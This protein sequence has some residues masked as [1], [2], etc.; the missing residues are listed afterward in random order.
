VIKIDSSGIR[1]MLES[2][3]AGKLANRVS[4]AGEKLPGSKPFWLNAQHQLI[5]QIRSPDCGSPH[6]FFTA[7]SA[8]IQ[9]PDLHQHMPSHILEHKKMQ[10]HTAEE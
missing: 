10:P 7:S 4:H 8:D 5:A 1:E 9:W 6:V 3:E 2:G